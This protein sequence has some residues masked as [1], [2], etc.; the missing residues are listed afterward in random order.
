MENNKNDNKVVSGLTFQ[1][2]DIIKIKLKSTYIDNNMKENIKK[3]FDYPISSF[4]NGEGR[5]TFNDTDQIV[6]KY[7]PNKKFIGQLRFESYFHNEVYKCHNNGEECHS[8]GDIKYKPDIT[9]TELLNI[10][11]WEKIYFYQEGINDEQE[12]IIIFK[13]V[14]GF[15]VYFIAGCDYTGFDC[16]GTGDISFSDNKKNFWKANNMQSTSMSSIAIT[17]TPSSW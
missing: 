17:Q 3:I 1:K 2:K 4:L 9:P 10:N 15:Y 8:I 13:T 5:W 7:K 12:W 6:K 14:D 11:K 16:Q